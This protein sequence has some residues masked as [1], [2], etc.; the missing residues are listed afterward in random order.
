MR[1]PDCETRFE[2]VVYRQTRPRYAEINDRLLAASARAGGRFH[3][4][5]EFG[6][7]HVS[8]DPETT[9][10]E[11]RRAAVA[12]DLELPDVFPRI[13]FAIEARL[14]RVLDRTLPGCAARYGLPQA[15][16]DV[17]TWP[18]CQEA[19]RQARNEGIEAIRFRS[20]SGAGENLA[21]FLDPLHP[22]SHVRIRN[23]HELRFPG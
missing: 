5:G 2:G 19:A 13:L 14:G 21:I 6:A 4:A 10:R 18:A 9:L 11:L 7:L 12:E 23:E 3:P 16:P 20:L 17:W 8:L 1:R 15:A 22:G